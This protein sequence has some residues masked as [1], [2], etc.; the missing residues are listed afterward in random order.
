MEASVQ[1]HAPAALPPG[2][3]PPGAHWMGGWVIYISKSEAHMWRRSKEADSFYSGGPGFWIGGR[4]GTRVVLY[5]YIYI[6]VC[7]CVCVC[8][9]G[10]HG[11]W[12]SPL[13]AHYLHRTTQHRKTRT[14]TSMPQAGFE[15]AFSTFQWSNTHVLQTS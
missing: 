9:I 6:C 11:R 2:K 7:V 3:E 15:Y 14:Y 10:L 8:V 1:L 4:M 12:V 5:I 13:Q